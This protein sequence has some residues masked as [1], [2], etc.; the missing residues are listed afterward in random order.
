MNAGRQFRER[1]QCRRGLAR[2]QVRE[3]FVLAAGEDGRL[4]ST[5]L[6]PEK[7]DGGKRNLRAKRSCG[8]FARFESERARGFMDRLTHARRRKL[9]PQALVIELYSVE[10]AKITQQPDEIRRRNASRVLPL[11]GALTTSDE[12]DGCR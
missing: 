6:C 5:V 7:G 4:Q 11:P 2:K 3:L 12:L 8:K 1:H 9:L 10:T